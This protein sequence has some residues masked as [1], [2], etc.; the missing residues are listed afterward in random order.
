MCVVR[1]GAG[2]G[3][4]LPWNHQR[5]LSS[6]A[7]SGRWD[8]VCS[9]WLSQTKCPRNEGGDLM[10]DLFGVSHRPLCDFGLSGHR[11]AQVEGG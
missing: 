8:A 1:G 11:L 7:V 9:S 6:I 4:G 5:G 10:A 2:W 3:A